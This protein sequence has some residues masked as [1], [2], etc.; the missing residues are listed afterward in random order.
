MDA[1]RSRQPVIL[2]QPLSL[3]AERWQSFGRNGHVPRMPD[4]SGELVDDD[5][6]KERLANLDK[7]W[8]PQAIEQHDEEIDGLWFF[9]EPR[10]AAARKRYRVSLLM[11]GQSW[12]FLMADLLSVSS[13]T[14]RSSSS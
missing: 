8:H 14:I 4:E 10:R 7:P 12:H 1:G 5:W 9:S 6:E 13:C 11:Y 3:T 2:H